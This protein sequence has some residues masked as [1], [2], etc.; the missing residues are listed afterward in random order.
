MVKPCILLLHF[1]LGLKRSKSQKSMLFH[2]YDKHFHFLFS[3]LQ[4]FTTY[5][6]VGI[7][8][9]LY[10]LPLLLKY[11]EYR[12]MDSML[13]Y[14]TF[15]YHCL[16]HGDTVALYHPNCFNLLNMVPL[17]KNFTCSFEILLKYSCFF[18]F[19]T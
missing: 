9:I 16:S 14:H 3:F 11:C 17:L 6:Q 12:I 19:L 18:I 10:V 4:M 13:A 8:L 1:H 15:I 5:P 7:E 2:D